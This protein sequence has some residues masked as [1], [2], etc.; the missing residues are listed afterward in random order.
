[1]VISG[2][3]LAVVAWRGLPDWQFLPISV[4][5]ALDNRERLSFVFG[6]LARWSVESD[7]S[8]PSVWL[9]GLLGLGLSVARRGVRHPDLLPLVSAAYL[10]VM[11]TAYLFSAFV[12]YQTHVLASL[13]R[14]MAH[15]A[16][17]VG[18]WVVSR[19]LDARPGLARLPRPRPADAAPAIP[20]GSSTDRRTPAL[21]GLGTPSGATLLPRP[22]PG[23]PPD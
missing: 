14:L 12:P 8:F 3:W 18:V 17:V 2:P 10:L 5:T 13:G 6:T 20:R 15:V 16:P 21:E 7:W 11:S 22:R 4:Q 23:T 1:V 19:W 9:L